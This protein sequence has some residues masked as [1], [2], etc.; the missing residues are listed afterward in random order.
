MRFASLG[1]GSRGNA[2]LVE[3]G[4]TL[5]MV[6]CGFS[7]IETERRMA[8]LGCSPDHL[9]AILVTHEHGDHVRGV[10]PLA[11]KYR[12]PVWL[13]NGTRMVLRDNNLPEVH[14]F[15]GH[16]DFQVGDL[17]IHPF[18]VPHDAREPCQFR[19]SDGNLRFGLLTD[20]GRMT[21]H[22]RDCLD[23]SDA[24]LLE[25]N[26]DAAMLADGPYPDALKRRVGGPLGHLSNAQAATLLE[27]IDTSRLQ[28][29]VAAH[30]SDKNNRPALAVDALAAVLGCER[31]WVGIADQ[32]V[33]FDWRSL[34]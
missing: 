22:I 17:Q 24:L 33:G 15:N 18:T 30:L 21:S 12:L 27:Q 6:D 5:V 2:T 25:C 3:A 28:H 7:C 34:F 11:R 16:T 14:P 31:T 10:A 1:S 13:T 26:H 9:S 29:I 20:T 8:R 32:A 23:G 19:F 4:S